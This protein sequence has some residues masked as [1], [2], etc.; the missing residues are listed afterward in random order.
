MTLKIGP[1]QEISSSISF[2]LQRLGIGST[3]KS[4]TTRHGR[5]CAQK[6]SWPF[7]ERP[8]CSPSTGTPSS[9]SSKRST[10]MSERDPPRGMPGLGLASSR[11]NQP[12][13]KT[14]ASS[15]WSRFATSIGRRAI[16][17]RNTSIFST[18]FPVTLSWSNG[19]VTASTRRS[20]VG[21]RLGLPTACVAIG[22]LFCMCPNAS[23]RTCDHEA[24]DGSAA[25][26]YL[27]IHR[28]HRYHQ[29]S[30]PMHE[31]YLIPPAQSFEH[32]QSWNAGN[33]APGVHIK[34]K[35][36]NLKIGGQ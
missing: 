1:F 29:P 6:A 3:Q 23:T 28:L 11:D 18:P 31:G 34:N 16:A 25:C 35:T 21:S 30:G 13:S 2:S 26:S 12:R 33:E 36:T 7:G 9:L 14:P 10:R 19:N 27:L 8:T 15:K 22:E 24:V 32:S 17:L 4:A 20:G 5:H